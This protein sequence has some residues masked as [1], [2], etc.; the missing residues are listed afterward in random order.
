MRFSNGSSSGGRRSSRIQALESQ[1]R[2]KMEKERSMERERAEEKGQPTRVRRERN[3]GKESEREKKTEKGTGGEVV[4]IGSDSEEDLSAEEDCKKKTNTKKNENANTFFL[5]KVCIYM[6]VSVCVS[7]CAY[8]ICWC[9]LSQQ[10]KAERRARELA[11][12]RKKEEEERQLA[13][14][15]AAIEREQRLLDQMRRSKQETDSRL[16]SGSTAGSTNSALAELFATSR[17]SALKKPPK[18]ETNAEEGANF[19]LLVSRSTDANTPI[20]PHTNIC[21]RM[22]S[23]TLGI[24]HLFLCRCF[25][26]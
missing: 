14:A 21:T 1:R 11:E 2:V 9:Y 5:S 23:H 22:Y 17:L 3:N 16:G 20:H 18:V 8:F 12:R 13:S 7:V 10:E 15:L 24:S 26:Q 25:R 19:E 4:I 6:Y